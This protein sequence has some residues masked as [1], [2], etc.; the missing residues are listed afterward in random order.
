M[1]ILEF[2]KRLITM[3]GFK[4]RTPRLP[5]NVE[6]FPDISAS[7]T[8]KSPSR[9]PISRQGF[10]RELRR[11]ISMYPRL[12]ATM[13]KGEKRMPE[14]KKAIQREMSTEFRIADHFGGYFADTPKARKKRH[15][16]ML[17]NLNRIHNAKNPTTM[18]PTA[19]KKIRRALRAYTA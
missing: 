4:K 2:L 7:H 14:G 12:N 9:T 15:I 3:L 17:A 1:F 18:R 19:P 6:S 8:S 11:R 5:A 10:K 16:R 13:A